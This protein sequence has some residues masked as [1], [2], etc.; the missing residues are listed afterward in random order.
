MF[1]HKLHNYL[2]FSGIPL[3]YP[4]ALE[5]LCKFISRST[6]IRQTNLEILDRWDFTLRSKL[7]WMDHS[8]LRRNDFTTSTIALSLVLVLYELERSLSYEELLLS[9]L[10]YQGYRRINFH[11]MIRARNNLW[12]SDLLN[13][14][15]RARSQDKSNLDIRIQTYMTQK[16]KVILSHVFRW[17]LEKRPTNDR[18]Q[19]PFTG[20]MNLTHFGR[21]D[22][23]TIMEEHCPYVCKK[24]AESSEEEAR[25]EG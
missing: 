24:L 19:S 10:P 11:G 15:S 8:V 1:S 16:R 17:F 7:G 18:Q 3:L 20:L 13:A 22:L 25:E 23:T 2:G 12:F 6:G 9:S 21:L 4:L 5:T 14:V